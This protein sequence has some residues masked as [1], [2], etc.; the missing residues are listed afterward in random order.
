M[1]TPA[2]TLMVVRSVFTAR[3]T[4]SDLWIDSQWQC[5]GLEPTCRKQA[6]V[7]LAIPQGKYELVMYESPR[8]L[9]KVAKWKAE[10]KVL[11]PLVEAGRVPL[12]LKVPAH[13]FVEIHPGN[14]PED[15]E[16]CLLPGQGIAA[17]WVSN[18]TPAWIALVT[19]I[20]EKLKAGKYYLGITGGGPTA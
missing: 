13:D 14:K 12:L 10:G 2:D 4:I 9:K 18:S 5:Y 8:M 6:G 19:K 20:E 7:K 11:H 15:T 1:T 3:S 16:D 17:D